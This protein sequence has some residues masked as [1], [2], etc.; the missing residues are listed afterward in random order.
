[1]YDQILSNATNR[2]FLMDQLWVILDEI[3]SD[4]HKVVV[5]GFVK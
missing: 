2:V 3:C 4:V 1:M 5:D